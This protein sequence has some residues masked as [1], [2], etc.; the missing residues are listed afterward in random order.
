[1]SP[2]TKVCVNCRG[3]TKVSI[4]TNII[5]ETDHI[6]Y[7]DNIDAPKG[8]NFQKDTYSVSSDD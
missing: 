6:S 3:F 7:P 4:N 1:M 8:F 5:P 2:T